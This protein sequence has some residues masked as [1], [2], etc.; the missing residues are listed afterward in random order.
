MLT[1]TQR[2]TTHWP[3]LLNF[4]RAGHASCMC[5]WR[6]I[7]RSGC[8]S[9]YKSEKAVPL[10][11]LPLLRGPGYLRQGLDV[12][13]ITTYLVYVTILDTYVMGYMW[14]HLWFD[15]VE[16]ASSTAWPGT[17]TKLQMGRA[18][19]VI[20]YNMCVSRPPLIIRCNSLPYIKEP[21]PGRLTNNAEQYLNANR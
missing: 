20:L 1:H 10:I 14:Q 13:I 6:T 4:Q 3:K 5:D 16:L 18:R 15:A 17:C 2:T 11:D 12:I 9:R 7:F 8:V 21:E 19:P